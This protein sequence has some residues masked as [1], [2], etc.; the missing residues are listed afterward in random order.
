MSEVI[1][2]SGQVILRSKGSQEDMHMDLERATKNKIK[3]LWSQWRLPE[4]KLIEKEK[5]IQNNIM[6]KGW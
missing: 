3:W 4:N 6:Q 2:I 1:C 5:K